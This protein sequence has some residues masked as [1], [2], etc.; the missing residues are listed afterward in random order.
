MLGYTVV[1]DDRDDRRNVYVFGAALDWSVAAGWHLAAEVAGTG[2]SERGAGPDPVSALLGV[3]Y[4]VTR[5]LV[6]DVSTRYGFNESV[7]RW[8]VGAGLTLTF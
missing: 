1:A 8:T 2:Q 7:P 3:I 6:I 4:E 5:T